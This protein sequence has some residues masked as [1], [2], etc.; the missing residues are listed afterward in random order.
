MNQQPYTCPRCHNTFP[1]SNKILH[2]LRCQGSNTSHSHYSNSNNNNNINNYNP[3]NNNFNNNNFN[4]N[5]FNNNNFN[6]RN[7]NNMN[8]NIISTN[9]N[10]MS[11]PDGTI[12]EIKTE[13]FQNGQ[14]KITKKKY[15]QSG[16][17]IS[18]QINYRNINDYNNFNNNSG[19]IISVQR[20]TDSYGN[21]TETRIEALP[22][23][24]TRTI[25][26]TKD[27]NG[28][29]I[30]QSINTSG[31]NFNNMNM[32]N[33]GM[34][35]MMNNMY[36]MNNMN[37][38][39]NNMFMNNMM[40][41][42]DI[43]NNISNGVDPNI[44][45]SLEVSKMNDV[46]HLNDEKKQCLICLEDFKNGDEVIY[47]PCLHVFHKDCLLEWFREHNYCPICKFKLTYENMNQN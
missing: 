46:S 38:M 9:N 35:N 23:G 28:N 19:N 30:G 6:N 10:R 12:T 14:Q 37:N 39:M 2:D 45:D 27:R 25:T 41:M 15:D 3:N 16:N 13:T 7:N 36:N 21:V 1:L 33:M 31:G 4:N 43:N 24:G 44:I 47:L 32:F 5:N 29:I 20:S 8:R 18:R 42:N 34:N 17:I 22:N 11:N 40:N 26:I